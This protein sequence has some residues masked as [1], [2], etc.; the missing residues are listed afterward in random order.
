MKRL[1]SLFHLPVLLSL[2]L[3][4]G[5]NAQKE[6]TKIDSEDQQKLISFAEAAIIALP[7]ANITA[8]EKK[9]IAATKPVVFVHYTGNKTG[10]YSITWNI[11]QKTITYAGNGNITSPESSSSKINIISVDT[12]PLK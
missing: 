8:A 10:R 1:K 5:C 7:E 2:L 6:Y 12:N 4:F 9:A 3:T 11:N